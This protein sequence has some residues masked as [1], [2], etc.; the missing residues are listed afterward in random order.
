MT[1]Y[2]KTVYTLSIKNTIRNIHYICLTKPV[3]FANTNIYKV[4]KM[5]TTSFIDIDTDIIL[6]RKCVS[7]KNIKELIL[8][9]FK[10]KYPRHSHNSTYFIGDAEDM[11]DT[12]S[13]VIKKERKVEKKIEERHSISG[14]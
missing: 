14:L 3:K 5:T 12:I 8:D 11:A 4:D 9:K 2:V 1:F 7:S 13:D 6:L 10:E